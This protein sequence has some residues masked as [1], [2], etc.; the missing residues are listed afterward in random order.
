MTPKIRKR[1]KANRVFAYLPIRDHFGS[2]PGRMQWDLCGH[3]M[4]YWALKA[5]AGSKHLEKVLV[6]TEMENAEAIAKQ[7]SDK[8]IILKRTLEECKE[9]MYVIV[10]DLKTP[11]SVVPRYSVISQ[12]RKVPEAL[13]FEPTFM[14]VV[15]SNL[16]L[17][18]SKDLD[19]MIERYFDD[20]EACMAVLVRHIDPN[21]WKKNPLAPQ[22]MLPAWGAPPATNNRQEYEQPYQVCGVRGYA[23][24]G[25]GKPKFGKSTFWEVSWEAGIDVHSKEDLELA[26]FYMRRRLRDEK[27]H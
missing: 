24:Q 14:L 20:D 9:P 27:H 1:I 5:A 13:G 26:E 23:Y 25:I 12:P 2:H 10:D 22:Y 4:F 11:Q 21:I 15:A 6:W 8:I 7:I 16:P 18:Q 3:P 19:M 17:V